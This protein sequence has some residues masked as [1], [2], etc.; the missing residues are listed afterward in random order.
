MNP[1]QRNTPVCFNKRAAR[2]GHQ[3][4]GGGYEGVAAQ[5]GGER[6]EKEEAAHARWRGLVVVKGAHKRVCCPS[7]GQTYTLCAPIPPPSPGS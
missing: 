6:H 7:V 5:C 4:R 1:V 2:P 3:G